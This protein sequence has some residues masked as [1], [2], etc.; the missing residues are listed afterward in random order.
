MI[1]RDIDGE[2]RVF[3]RIEDRRTSKGRALIILARAEN[4]KRQICRRLYPTR[5]SL[6]V[7]DSD[8]VGELR[9]RGNDGHARALRSVR[10][11]YSR[12]VGCTV[13]GG[14]GNTGAVDV[15]PTMEYHAMR[16]GRLLFTR[17]IP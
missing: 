12:V 15:R 6:T 7:C 17:R 2:P 14:M 16:D 4:V 11:I 8:D 9:F 10:N 3:G 13:I 5:R 1:V